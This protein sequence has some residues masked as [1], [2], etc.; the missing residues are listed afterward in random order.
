MATTG[1]RTDFFR[2][3]GTLHLDSPSYVK[4]PADN[5]LFEQV[6]AGQFCY[7]LTP[8]Q[9]GKSSLMLR[10]AERLRQAGART[11]IV[12][13]SSLGTQ[14]ITSEQWYLGL[15]K[16]LGLELKLSVE[17]EQWWHA[18]S[19]LTA[20]QRFTDFLHE[21]VLA[22][23]QT[24]V[25]IFIDEI[26]STLRLPFTDD[27]FAAVRFVYNRRATQPE[28]DR[29]TFV[30]LGVAAPTDLIQ[31]SSRTPFNI[32]RAIDLREF[33][34]QDTQ[35]LQVG[36]EQV[37]PNQGQSLLD[38]IFYWTHGHPYLTQKLCFKVVETGGNT[39]TEQQVDAL[40]E[41]LFLT[42][43]AK[44]EDNLQFV[45]GNVEANPERR[46][47]LQ[48]YRR[49]YEGQAVKEDERSPLQNRLKL[50]GL[51]RV[52]N[53]I[54]HVR[55]EIYRRVFNQAWIKENT[56]IPWTQWVTIGAVIISILAV[57]FTLVFLRIQQQQTIETKV[58]IFTEGYYGSSDP[59]IRL[60]ALAD[61][62]QLDKKEVAQNLFFE[63]DQRQQL[64]IFR[65]VKAEA[66]GHKLETTV[67]CLHP[68]I[69]EKITDS[70]YRRTLSTSMCCALYRWQTAAG[71]RFS[72]QLGYP[73]QCETG[74]ED[75]DEQSE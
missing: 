55:N 16:R 7:V 41:K 33:S 64:D 61:L 37:Y 11:A 58:K 29:L 66:A 3:G 59:D 5:E 63:L 12:D 24:Q 35:P 38:R 20:V 50:F 49:V 75:G 68:A 46:P 67:A 9:M 65:K 17:P 26:D 27:F 71:Q 36:L 23:I 25:V 2:V 28:Y 54:L 43:D 30:L 40:V 14:E 48:L 69:P 73:C 53:R 31:D 70:E 47:L 52:E 1:Q 22:E 62:C 34:R 45:R 6:R 74:S 72:Q 19:A 13:L 42:E 10:T 18:R 57:I 60:N 32:G 51:V 21:V 39:W 4:R 56:P 44:K 15:I 8:R